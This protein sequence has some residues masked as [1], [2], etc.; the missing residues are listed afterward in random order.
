MCLGMFCKSCDFCEWIMDC[1]NIIAMYIL[2]N[3]CTCMLTTKRKSKIAKHS[4]RGQTHKIA[5]LTDMPNIPKVQHWD[6]IDYATVMLAT[7]NLLFT[8]VRH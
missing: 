5:L 8:S 7:C 4:S 1:K 6:A 3:N 2:C